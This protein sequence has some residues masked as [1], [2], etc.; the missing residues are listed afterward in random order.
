MI[1]SL[2]S[3]IV[4]RF[5]E[6]ITRFQ[7]HQLSS[8]FCPPP[9]LF[10]SLALGT[11]MF[12]ASFLH[13]TCLGVFNYMLAFFKLL[14]AEFCSILLVLHF[15]RQAVIID[16]PFK[17]CFKWF[18]GGSAVYSGANLATVPLCDSLLAP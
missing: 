14:T 8:P 2:Q 12:Q 1:H 3:L 6:H 18:G 4:I 11:V 15:S 7:P 17:V 5:L 10:V 16:Y 13:L 9:P